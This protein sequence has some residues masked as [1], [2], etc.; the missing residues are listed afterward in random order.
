LAEQR[1]TEP[2]PAPVCNWIA[3]SMHARVNL[4]DKHAILDAM[5]ERA[6]P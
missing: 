3:R 6:S 4:A 2:S 5:D 1:S